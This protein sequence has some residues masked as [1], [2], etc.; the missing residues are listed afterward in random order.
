MKRQY[1]LKFFVF[2]SYIL[3]HFHAFP[4][5]TSTCTIT[6][7]ANPT[8]I[9]AGEPVNL[10]A[11]TSCNQ[12][13]MN[14]NFNNGTVGNGWQ[15]TNQAMFSNP[16]GAGLDGTTHLW[17]GSTSPAPRNVTTVPFDVS[18]GGTICFEMKY[19]V[20]AAASPCE[21]PDLPDEGVHLQ[22]SVNNG[23]W[24]DID[25]WD[26]N[27]G[28]DPFLTQ[29]QN[30]CR[31]IPQAA[32]STSTRFRWA[33]VS[34]S[35]ND[36]DHWGLDNVVI[37][38][39][40]PN[41]TVQWSNGSSGY[42][43]PVVTPSA[44]TTYTATLTDNSGCTAATSITVTITDTIHETMSTISHCIGT[45]LTL[46]AA[47]GTGFTW[48]NGATTQAITIAPTSNT[49]LYVTITGNACVKV[50]TYPITIK[51]SPT[52]NFTYTPNPACA[53]QIVQFTNTS[54]ILQ[55][56]TGFGCPGGPFC[57][58]V[59]NPTLFSWIFNTGGLPE[60]TSENASYT[61]NIIGTQ[62][63]S[64]TLF[65]V[66]TQC[67]STISIPVNVIN[68]GSGCTTPTPVLTASTPVC[69][70]DSTIISITNLSDYV[71][72]TTFIWDF[73][74]GTS[75]PG[76][77]GGPHA[78]IWNSLGTYTVTL[79]VTEPGCIGVQ[80]SV[81]IDINPAPISSFTVTSPVCPDETSAIE[82]NGTAGTSAIYDWNFSGGNIA[83]GSGAGP[84]LVSW[85][86]S[87]TMNI[88]LNVTENGCSSSF[89]L[90]VVVLDSN[91]PICDTCY[92]PTPLITTNSPICI[93][94]SAI[95]T[96]AGSTT[97]I[98]NWNFDGGT[99]VPGTGPG[100]HTVTWTTTGTKTISVVA[101]EG[102]CVPDSATA[103]IIINSLPNA[104]AGQNQDIC[105]GDTA[106]LTA[107]GGA[108]YEWS[109]GGNAANTNVAPATTQIYIVTVTD[110][111]NCLQTDNVTV[112]V[113]N[114][115]NADAG[116][117]QNI[118]AGD[119][120]TLTANGGSNYLWSNNAGTQS[121]TVTPVSNTSYIVTVSDNFGCSSVDSVAVTIS[122]IPEVNFSSDISEGCQPLE[123]HFSSLQNLNIQSFF[124]NF[125]DP[126]AGVSNTSD[127]Q[128]PV[129]VFNTSGSFNIS[130]TVTNN[131][132]CSNNLIIN[133]MITVH[134]QPVA[135]FSY[136]ISEGNFDNTPVQFNDQSILATTWHW[137]FGE[138]ASVSENISTSPS[139]QHTYL[140][141]GSFI[142][143]LIVESERGCIDT[144]CK[145]VLIK[146]N[147]MFY[148]P[149]AFTPD[150]DGLND[151]FSVK[152][153]GF[154]TDTFLFY[155]FSRWGEEIFHT[156]D[157]NFRW[158]GTVKES[159]RIAPEGVY[160]WVVIVK[161]FNGETRK[162]FGTVT[163][164]K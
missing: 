39:P 40:P 73:N 21:G 133:N 140:T 118:C 62:Q 79:T 130:L 42:Y 47:S 94:Q 115:S 139:P 149:S 159:N 105:A 4:Q 22:Y 46:T 78:V 58:C 156:D 87:G 77:G 84:Y 86:N 1:L 74:G 3:F 26:P 72:G 11:Q 89:S 101:T 113:H 123:V 95:V 104:D 56:C 31:Q 122:P 102:Y 10:S 69:L 32:W 110:S 146:H 129:H 152:G 12:L 48:S 157:I 151:Y 100:P 82:F 80:A 109:N 91:N 16:C 53:G 132:G 98:Y 60:S 138:P 54:T 160:T 27:G 107:T 119:S 51:Q 63:A 147:I 29:W 36:Y 117:D 83:S 128:N 106:N 92:T 61:Y 155:I 96:A 85:T 49:T 19:S 161:D 148:S 144:S 57:I 71:T 18:N 99:A 55:T 125:N 124:W 93:N 17:M 5:C 137:N 88:S 97:T 45:D 142:A 24:I 135:N 66:L 120:A 15:S 25:Y 111:N 37:S 67:A 35:G 7:G 136:V 150:Q 6:A 127:L 30:Y 9:C 20:Q 43:P 75:N 116:T 143:C 65:D 14:N 154:N 34:S 50:V 108:Q 141:A 13:L 162:Y 52:A 23:P 68:C 153:I 163:L 2:F 164:L 33:Q 38:V 114:L 131:A 103:T 8:V 41:A 112:N 76:T 59:D 81:T 134:P 121:I 126:S 90:P 70:G 64:L 28:N 44:T 145:E 158:D